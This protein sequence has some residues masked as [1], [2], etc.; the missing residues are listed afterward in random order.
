MKFTKTAVADMWVIDLEPIGD[1]RGFF[2]RTFCES[3]FRDHGLQTDFVQSNMSYSAIAGVV[4]GLHLQVEPA[5][6]A[7]LIRCVKGAI[8]DVVVDTRRDSPTYLE[9]VSVALNDRNR[10]AV[11][12]PPLCAHGF[13][14]LEKDTEVNYLVSG[15]YTPDAERGYRYDDQAFG[16]EWPLD[17]TG[18]SE[19]D[20]QWPPFVSAPA[21]KPGS[22]PKKS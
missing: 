8:F 10:T 22:A 2:A 21:L 5:L 1:D 19:K 15:A 4:R 13:Q 16:I 12:V 20:K 9:H 11:Y 14:I 6:E 3:E 17:V 18:L 7:K